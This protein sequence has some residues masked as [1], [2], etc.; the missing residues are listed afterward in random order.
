MP[1]KLVRPGRSPEPEPEPEPQEPEPEATGEEEEPPL[2]VVEPL[3][4]SV[5]EACRILGGISKP[6]LYRLINTDQISP[7][8]IGKRS[9]F[10][11]R[12]LRRFVTGLEAEAG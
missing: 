6:S 2:A 10:T 4:Y 3:L 11:M 8:K 12:E 7:V 5:E 1:R 9:F